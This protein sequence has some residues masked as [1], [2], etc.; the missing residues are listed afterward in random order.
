MLFTVIPSVGRRGFY[1][2][3]HT[4]KQNVKN[5]QG[6]TRVF[7]TRADAQAFVGVAKS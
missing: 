7:K 3:C 1:L 5:T 2:Y 4:T 6:R